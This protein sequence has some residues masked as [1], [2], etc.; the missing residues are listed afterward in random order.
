MTVIFCKKGCTVSNIGYGL[1]MLG[2]LN[3]GLVGLSEFVHTDLNVVHML[4]GKW[5]SA[6]A[7]VYIIV[8]LSALMLCIGCKCN[9]CA[10]CRAEVGVEPRM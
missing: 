2:A 1:A 3:W 4:L 10:S 8:G 5:P 7:I 6:E 9:K